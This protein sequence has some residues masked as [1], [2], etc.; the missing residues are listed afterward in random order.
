MAADNPSYKYDLL[1]GHAVVAQ[2]QEDRRTKRFL[3]TALAISSLLN[4]LL[5]MRWFVSILEE[6]H[7]SNPGRSSYA[8]L[9][10]DVPVPFQWTSEY[11]DI[12]NPRLDELWQFDGMFDYGMIALTDSEIDS[13]HLLPSEQSFP[14]D[15]ENKSLYHLN[16][17]HGL[18]CLRL[19]YTSIS[20]YRA[21]TPQKTPFAHIMHCLDS[22]RQDIICAADDSPRYLTRNGSHS[23][24]SQVRFCRDFSKLN[25]WARE[26]DACFRQQH[27]LADVMAPIEKFKYCKTE[28]N[29]E[30]YLNRVKGYFDMPNDWQ[31]PEPAVPSW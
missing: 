18:H 25:E 23:G 29:R 15:P 27:D 22:I 13:L 9:L 4:V 3:Y 10:N 11:S 14:W 1:E 8:G 20:S 19:I 17:H 12:N 24:E 30:K 31:F 2:S 6:T 16:G 7:F 26:R 21:S 28:E 5:A